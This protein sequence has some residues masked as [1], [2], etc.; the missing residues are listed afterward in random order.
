MCF[1]SPF[2]CKLYSS[3]PTK[4]ERERN[5]GIKKAFLDGAAFDWLPLQSH[6]GLSN[7]R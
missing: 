7:N 6:G 5:A 4:R 1:S 3:T 2:S